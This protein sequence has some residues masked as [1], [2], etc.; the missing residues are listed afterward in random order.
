MCSESIDLIVNV[1]CQGRREHR[2]TKWPQGEADFRGSHFTTTF[3]L[4]LSK[5][6]PATGLGVNMLSNNVN[7]TVLGVMLSVKVFCTVSGNFVLL[8]ATKCWES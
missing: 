4:L 2:G 7:K 3:L 1:T 6:V 8:T 5:I